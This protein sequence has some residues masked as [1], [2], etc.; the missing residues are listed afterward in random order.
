MQ[1]AA[2]ISDKEPWGQS[3]ELAAK[4]L[5]GSFPY[6]GRYLLMLLANVKSVSAGRL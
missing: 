6:H 5:T 3:G 2:L 1:P 4:P